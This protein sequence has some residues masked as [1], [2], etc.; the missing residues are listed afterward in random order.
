MPMFSSNPY[1][2]ILVQST[3]VSSGSSVPKTKISEMHQVLLLRTYRLRACHRHTFFRLFQHYYPIVSFWVSAGRGSS[4]AGT[5]PKLPVDALVYCSN[6]SIDD[7]GSR[8]W[9]GKCYLA[10]SFQN[11][12]SMDASVWYDTEKGM[13][14]DRIGYPYTGNT[15]TSSL[16]FKRNG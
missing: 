15:N 3:W 7:D 10:S 14:H 1:L 13:Q 2:R 5:Y 16:F 11:K 8:R 4:R 12:V 9:Y 6:P